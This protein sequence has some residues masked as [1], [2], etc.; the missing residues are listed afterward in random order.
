MN[1]KAVS[2]V[3][4]VILM[5][6]ITVAIAA[7][8]YVYVS[9]TFQSDD[10]IVINQIDIAENY[11]VAVIYY[12]LVD[13]TNFYI[14]EIMLVDTSTQNFTTIDG[15]LF[16]WETNILYYDGNSPLISLKEKEDI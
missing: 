5:V 2:E 9:N 16:D 4:G 1:N 7:T 6:A 13:D 14:V 10:T 8:V 15:F 11:V 12:D 3:I